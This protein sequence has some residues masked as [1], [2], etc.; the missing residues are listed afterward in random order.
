M[1]LLPVSA[2]VYVCAAFS[3]LYYP[4]LLSA[5]RAYDQAVL[6]LALVGIVPQS[7]SQQGAIKLNFPAQEYLG[8]LLP[9]R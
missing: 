5:A 4:D 8:K 3:F 6:S 2:S 7:I 9:E 1:G